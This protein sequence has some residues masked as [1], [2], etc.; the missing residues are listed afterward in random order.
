MTNYCLFKNQ[1]FYNE[2]RWTS[3]SL[4]RSYRCWG[5]ISFYLQAEKRTGHVFETFWKASGETDHQQLA[6]VAGL[7]PPLCSVRDR[8]R[9]TPGYSLVQGSLSNLFGPYFLHATAKRLKIE[10]ISCQRS[11]WESQTQCKY[12]LYSGAGSNS[13]SGWA[14]Q[15]VELHKYIEDIHK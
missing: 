8:A 11:T 12:L 9:V 15:E 4:F 10:T 14:I 7:A 6:S 13:F 3:A 5:L 1:K 2:T